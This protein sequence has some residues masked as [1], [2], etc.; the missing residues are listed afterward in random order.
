M[1]LAPLL[2]KWG[3]VTSKSNG[4]VRTPF[5]RVHALGAKQ[6]WFQL[7][8]TP[9]PPSAGP[10][11]KNHWELTIYWHNI[12]ERRMVFSYRAED[13]IDLAQFAERRLLL[14]DAKARLGWVPGYE[15]HPSDYRGPLP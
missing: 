14:L 5:V 13:A 10:F 11:G 1:E 2:K 7:K 8:L 9:L 6:P 4:A 3:W 15:N 12:G